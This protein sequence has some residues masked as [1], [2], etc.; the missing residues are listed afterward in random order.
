M[1]TI[2][3]APESLYLDDSEQRL[4]ALARLLDQA[5]QVEPAGT[6]THVHT[7]Y[8]FSCF[9]SPTEAA[10]LAKASWRRSLRHQRSLHHRRPCRIR[11]SLRIACRFQ[12]PF[13]IESVAVDRQAEQAGTLFNDP[14]NPGEST[15]RAKASPI[16]TMN[17]PLRCLEQLRHHQSGRNQAMLVKAQQLFQHQLDDAGP[18]W[19]SIAAMTPTGNNTE[20]HLAR[21]IAERCAN[22]PKVMS[23]ITRSA[24][25]ALWCEAETEWAVLQNGLRSRC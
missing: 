20:R 25:E 15:C 6:N 5:P 22:W 11:R 24:S 21:A 23:K 7:N 3:N 8:S 17:K 12:P 13:S 9:H 10:W 19:E 2:T 16:A 18:Q 1:S 14:G 4:A